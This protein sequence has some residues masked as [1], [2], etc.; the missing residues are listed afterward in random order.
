MKKI[1]ALTLALVMCLGVVAFAA[2]VFD[3]SLDIKVT[4][5]DAQLEFDVKPVTEEGRTLVP[6][7]KIFET[8]GATV[9]YDDATRTVIS[10]KGDLIIV[11]QIDNNVMFVNSAPVQLQVPAREVGGRT[12]VPLRAIGDA[13]GVDVAWDEATTTAKLFT[14]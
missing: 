7:R 9:D 14:K 3:T 2:P 11:M 10:R 1:I 8:L 4:L 12:L 13:M 5:D 6:V